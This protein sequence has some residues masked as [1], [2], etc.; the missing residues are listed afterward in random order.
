DG[1]LARGPI[2]ALRARL[3]EELAPLCEVPYAFY[4]HS[5]GG[6]FALDLASEL[7]RLGKGPQFVG[8][9]AVPT[10][11]L[12][13]S[14]VPA[15]ADTPADVDDASVVAALARLHVPRDLL[16]CAS[17]RAE[18]VRAARRDLWLG[19][20]AGF[21]DG[22]FAPTLRTVACGVVVAQGRDDPIETMSATHV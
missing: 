1:A 21:G 12:M 22:Q 19:V 4:G 15:R 7:A 6:W 3:L 5:V 18:L 17:T 16:D 11:Y 8:L 14:I 10:A 20:Q 9:G 2:Q 13:R